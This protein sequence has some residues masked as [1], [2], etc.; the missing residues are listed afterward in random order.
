MSLELA[1]L[2]DDFEVREGTLL[3]EKKLAL[4]GRCGQDCLS[5]CAD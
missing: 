1:V 3:E 5:H 2:A 4:R